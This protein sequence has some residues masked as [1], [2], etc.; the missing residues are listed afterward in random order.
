M[1]SYFLF[2]RYPKAEGRRV[3][4]FFYELCV[5]KLIIFLFCLGN[6]GTGILAMPDAIKNSGLILGNVGRKYKQLVSANPVCRVKGTVDI[7]LK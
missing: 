1:Q 2:V 6:I 4:S 5:K 3:P 7:D